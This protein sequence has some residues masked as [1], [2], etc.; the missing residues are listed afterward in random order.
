MAQFAPEL[1]PWPRSTAGVHPDVGGA[2][3]PEG[4]KRHIS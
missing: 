1:Q 2:A 3:L 4:R